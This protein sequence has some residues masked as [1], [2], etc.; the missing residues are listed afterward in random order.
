MEHPL[1][2]SKIQLI[3][4]LIIGTIL[5]ALFAYFIPNIETG[6]NCINCDFYTY[7][8]DWYN[9][10]SSKM[11]N[12]D[13]RIPQPDGLYTFDEIKQRFYFYL[14]LKILLVGICSF[15]LA[16]YSLNKIFNNGK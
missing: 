7:R 3:I 4:S 2:K 5:S 15:S 8:N 11:P 6:F 9:D 13:G 14:C 12:W 1:Q 16:F 10:F